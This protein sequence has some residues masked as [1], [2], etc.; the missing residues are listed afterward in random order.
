MDAIQKQWRM[1]AKEADEV[2]RNRPKLLT[3][4]RE[5]HT[6]AKE[7]MLDLTNCWVPG[8]NKD[9]KWLNYGIVYDHMYMDERHCPVTRRCIYEAF[10]DRVF[11][12]GFS[13]LASG[14]TI[15][16]HTDESKECHRVSYH[17]GLDVPAGCA[18]QVVGSPDLVEKN[19]KVLTF[20]DTNSHQAVNPSSSDRVILYVKVQES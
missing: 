2:K 9:P 3:E 10:G 17:L 13:W 11:L 16:W 6:P 5:R 4:H 12:A 1:I 15:P 7:N 8:W 14:A 19:G 18:L 20:K